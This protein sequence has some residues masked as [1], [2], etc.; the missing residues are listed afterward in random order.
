MQRR[1][2]LAV[3][4]VIPMVGCAAI[5]TGNLLLNLFEFPYYADYTWVSEFVSKN[6]AASRWLIHLRLQA[7]VFQTLESMY[8]A[9]DFMPA[10]FRDPLSLARA[11]NM[12]L[13][14]AT[15]IHCYFFYPKLRG[16]IGWVI[17]SAAYCFMATGYGK[18]YGAATAILLLLYC[19]LAESEFEGD[20]VALGVISALVGLYYLALMPIAFAILLTVLIKRPQAFLPALLS[21]VVA[22]YVLITIFWG[23]NVVAYFGSLWSESHFG[24]PYTAYG[25][26]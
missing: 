12:A 20:G 3:Y 24:N 17:S 11:L 13:L 25:P 15:G 22:G 6:I 16:T 7:A 1:S 2:F 10:F 9:R 21:F 14:V 19:A 4:P 5:G 8:F 23:Q 18:V 26:Y